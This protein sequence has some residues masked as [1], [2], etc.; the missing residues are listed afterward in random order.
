MI[1]DVRTLLVIASLPLIIMPFMSLSSLYLQQIQVSNVIIIDKDCSNSSLPGFG[2]ISSSY[3]V[4]L[5]AEKLREN[6]FNVYLVTCSNESVPLPKKY[7]LVVTIPKGFV[8]NLTS[9]TNASIIKVNKVIG[10]SRADVA[11]NIINNV[12]ADIASN[13]S[14]GKI[15]LLA[16]LAHVKVVADVVLY[17]IRM[18]MGMVTPSGA[19]AT[20]A[21]ELRTRLARIMAFS[22]LFVTTPSIAYITDSIV[23]E[24]ERRTIEALL[25]TPVPRYALVIGKVFTASV[26]GLIAGL[27][28]ALGL[29]IFFILPSI[30]YGMNVI[31]YL[32][33]SLIVTHVAAVYLSVFTSLAIIVP[34]IIR[35]GSYRA[36]YAASLTVISLASV[37]FFIS[38]FVNIS[39]LPTPIRE[40]LYVVPYTHAVIMIKQVVFGNLVRV[41]THALVI[42]GESVALIGLAIKLFN[43]EKIIYSKT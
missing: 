22:L 27:S 7:D 32:T 13:V 20:Y 23:G 1:R 41:L 39:S 38:L 29:L 26:I 28:D 2:T 9:L 11:V 31:S 33:P 37:V 6:K 8:S 24:K 35:S 15:R 19:P 25:A 5:M 30:V 42:V 4:H 36:S 14:K 12:L 17:P 18:V 3:V 40:L 10:S 43:D 16:R 34:I 21:E